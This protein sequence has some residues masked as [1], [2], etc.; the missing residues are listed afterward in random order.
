MHEHEDGRGASE[1][2]WLRS[3]DFWFDCR[4][5]QLF[6]FS[7]GEKNSG[8]TVLAFACERRRRLWLVFK[9]TR[10]QLE[11][12]WKTSPSS[13]A[14]R[15][16]LEQNVSPTL[17]QTHHRYLLLLILFIWIMCFMVSDK[18]SCLMHSCLGCHGDD[19]P[20]SFVSKNVRKFVSWLLMMTRPDCR[21]RHEDR[22]H[23]HGPGNDY[24]TRLSLASFHCNVRASRS[25]P[26]THC[27]REQSL[28]LGK[29]ASAFCVFTVW[30]VQFQAHKWKHL[31]FLLNLQ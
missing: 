14:G 21:E 16:D 28:N 6:Y 29:T 31:C 5:K 8:F 25:W 12:F 13:S 27:T 9:Q 17:S 30:P 18:D 23:V 24:Q 11:L 10:T 20:T 4:L 22:R 26:R 1:R 7:H 15:L 2:L 3:R 19:F